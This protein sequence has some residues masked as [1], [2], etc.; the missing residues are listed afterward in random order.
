MQTDSMTGK[1]AFKLTGK[2]AGNKTRKQADKQLGI[3]EQANARE[4]RVV[5]AN[6]ESDRAGLLEVRIRA[7]EQRAKSS[8]IT[9]TVRIPKALNEWLDEYVHGSWPERVLKQGLIIEALKL[10]YARRGRP[11]EQVLETELL[12]EPSHE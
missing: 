8:S 10:L 3:G 5:A 12:R 2:Q 7:A 11:G 1:Q 4:E 9:V 6:H